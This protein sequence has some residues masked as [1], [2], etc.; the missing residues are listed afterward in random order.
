M[1]EKISRLKTPKG[2]AKVAIPFH[3][4]E[5]STSVATSSS[6]YRILDIVDFLEA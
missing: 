6:F 1:Q 4:S 2:F 5:V 3:L